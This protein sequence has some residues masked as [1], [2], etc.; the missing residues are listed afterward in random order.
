M[1]KQS[2]YEHTR[3]VYNKLGKQYIKDSKK[4]DPIERLAFV[5]N[6]TKGSHILDVGCGGGRDSKFFA[7][8]G[9]YTTGIDASDVFI[10]EARKTI[11][12]AKFIQGDLLKI[13]FPNNSF[14]GIWSQAVLHH[15]K[16]SDIPKAIKK[17]HRIMKPGGLLHIRV[18]KGSGEGYEKEKLSRWNDRF[19]TYVSK[20]ELGEYL[21]DAGFKIVQSG[22]FPDQLKR[23][24]MNWILFWA[25]K[26]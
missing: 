24:N 5:K 20:K 14:D 10:D 23:K 13:P 7:T 11:P 6:F 9:M 17:F 22:I 21:K 2:I 4:L 16:R 15:L 3:A 19:Y 25:R 18:K 12:K 1:K 26:S 8:S